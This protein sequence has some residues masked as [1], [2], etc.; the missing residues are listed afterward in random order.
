[1]SIRF[2]S[3]VEFK[4]CVYVYTYQEVADYMNQY[5][6]NTGSNLAKEFDDNWSK[7]ECKINTDSTFKFD[8]VT[9][10]QI[11]NQRFLW[12]PCQI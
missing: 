6:V 9:E 7:E 4:K 10:S 5:Y 1:M 3:H 12:Q 11:E 2:I 8:F